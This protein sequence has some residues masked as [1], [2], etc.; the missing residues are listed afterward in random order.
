MQKQGRLD[1]A[2]KICLE[3]SDVARTQFGP[4]SAVALGCKL[5]LATILSDKGEHIPALAIQR[6]VLQIQEEALGSSHED[7][8]CTLSNLSETL[9]ELEQYD[10]AVTALKRL[11]SAL[12]Q[13]LGVCDPEA[14]SARLDLSMLL[15]RIDLI[16][17]AEDIVA[18]V[19]SGREGAED[20]EL[21]FKLRKAVNVLLQHGRT[22]PFNK[23]YLGH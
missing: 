5:R 2:E 8:C 3:I 18:N 12:E 20:G 19:I 13:R 7:T 15:A 23:F 17:E 9:V 22:A 1:E 21:L 10:E 16:D 14:L 11:V 4:E 6:E